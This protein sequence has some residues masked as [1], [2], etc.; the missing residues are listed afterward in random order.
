MGPAEIAATLEDWSLT[1]VT[2]DSGEAARIP[3]KWRPIVLSAEAEDRRRTALS[4]WNQSFLDLVPEFAEALNTHC[5]DVR[6]CLTDGSSVLVYVLETDDGELVS[7]V[8]YDP[9]T[10]EEPPFW[11]SFP[12]AVQVFLREVHAGFVSGSREAFGV[13]RPAAMGTVAELAD[14]PEGVPG[15]EGESRI[16]STRLLE[17]TTDGGLLKYC[18][19]PDLEVG[20]VALVYEG[21]I[22]PKDFGPELDD[23]LMSRF[24][25]PS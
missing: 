2:G 24:E 18:L 19:S 3:R 23:L 1:F 6:V 12:Q 17:I 7:W 8:G 13:A 4:L 20:K 15:W 16:S 9:V 22:D 25:E 5:V 21:D 10:F 14:F 11:E